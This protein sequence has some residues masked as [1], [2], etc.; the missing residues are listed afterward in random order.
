MRVLVDTSVWSLALRRRNPVSSP[1]AD[2][3]ADLIADGRAVMIGAVR[4]EILSGIRHIAQFDR[5]RYALDAFPDE[6]VDTEDY[7]EA[8]SICNRCLDAGVLTGNTDCL[9]SAVAILRD[10]EV[11]TMDRDFHHMS[12]VVPVRIHKTG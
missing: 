12:S 3:L 4:Q 7:I 5:L 8:A 1:E 10:M 9:I 11:L 2:A 6:T